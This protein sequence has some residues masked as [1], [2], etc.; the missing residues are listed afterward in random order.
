MLPLS[1]MSSGGPN[2]LVRR[3]HVRILVPITPLNVEEQARR[4]TNGF[5]GAAD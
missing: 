3:S 1:A 5:A 2:R 4:P